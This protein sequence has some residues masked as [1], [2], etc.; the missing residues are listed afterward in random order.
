MFKKIKAGM[1]ALLLSV[2][3]CSSVAQAEDVI[4]LG[5][6]LEL[7]GDYSEQGYSAYEGVRL[8]VDEVNRQGGVSG[9]KVI[10]ITGQAGTGRRVFRQSWHSR[11]CRH[12]KIGCIRLAYPV[13]GILPPVRCRRSVCLKQG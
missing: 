13:P 4:R 2:G 6:N 8:A 11:C 7:T 1:V 9:K 5:I 12:Y 10:L 3:V